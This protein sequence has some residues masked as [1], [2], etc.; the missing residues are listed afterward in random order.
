MTTLLAIDTATDALS[1]ALR[2]DGELR[3]IH[4][5]MPRQH[6]QQLFACLDELF[7]GQ[8]PTELGL[9]AVVYGRGPGSFTGLRIAAS[10]AQGLAYSL[11]IPVIGVSTL[12]TQVRTLLRREGTYRASGDAPADRSLEAGLILSTIDARIGQAYAAF[13]QVDGLE[14]SALGDPM[15]AEPASLE[16][17][18]DTAVSPLIVV[19][20]GYAKIEDL[21]QSLAPIASLWPDVKP[22][23]EDMFAVAEALLVAGEGRSAATAMPDYVQQRI[24]WKTLAEQARR[25]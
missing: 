4:R 21:P 2:R 24:G 17:P 7:E 18:T 23:A 5:V 10:A 6:Q 3:R 25:P 16:R 20:D 14:V 22:E 12:E 13:F 8:T 19:G 9:Q 1:L 15:V 11:D